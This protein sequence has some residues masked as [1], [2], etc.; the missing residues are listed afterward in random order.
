M[1]IQDLSRV[2]GGFARR[3][4]QGRPIL[5]CL[6]NARQECI[7]PRAVAIMETVFHQVA[8]GQSLWEPIKRLELPS[9]ARRFIYQV[10]TSQEALDP[11]R[12]LGDF[13]R[14]LAEAGEEEASP[15]REHP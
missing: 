1:P 11:A 7:D 15:G 4:K 9:A 14:V 2:F 3:V 5:K 6:E 13:S 8:S 12:V 10:E